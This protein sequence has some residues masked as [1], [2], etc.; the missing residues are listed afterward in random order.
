MVIEPDWKHFLATAPRLRY[1]DTLNAA[2]RSIDTL[3][4]AVRNI[5]TLAR[6]ERQALHAIPFWLRDNVL[7]VG[8]SGPAIHVRRPQ[9]PSTDNE[10]GDFERTDSGLY[11]LRR[12]RPVGTTKVSQEEVL[13]A[14]RCFVE[15]YRQI[16]TQADLQ[17]AIA[18]F[19]N[20]RISQDRLR[21][22]YA[23]EW[24]GSW[25]GVQAHCARLL[26]GGN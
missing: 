6:I 17:R 10:P 15:K 26:A 2:L 22:H 18:R 11:I 19:C 14:L 20:K 3:N 5:D 25:D 7:S 4:A 16:P 8:Y 23:K 12:G 1:F 21:K 9:S 24:F 13:H